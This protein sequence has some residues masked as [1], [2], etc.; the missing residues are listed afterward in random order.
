[1]ALKNNFNRAQTIKDLPEEKKNDFGRNRQLTTFL[2][3]RALK[4]INGKDGPNYDRSDSLFLEDQET[5]NRLK[6]IM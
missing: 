5:A 4:R 3:T 1:M 2:K 6:S